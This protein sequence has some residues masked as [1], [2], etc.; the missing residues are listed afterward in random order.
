MKVNNPYKTFQNKHS[1]ENYLKE[2]SQR[3]SD[4]I[5]KEILNMLIKEANKPSNKSKYHK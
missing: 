1:F 5:D 4:E 3:I 2:S